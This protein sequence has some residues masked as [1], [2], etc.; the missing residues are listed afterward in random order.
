MKLR[1]KHGDLAIIIGDFPGCEENLGVIVKVVGPPELH[2]GTQ[3]ICWDIYPVKRRKL[4]L[5][6]GTTLFKTAIS[7]N[8]RAFHPDCWLLPIKG[9]DHSSALGSKIEKGLPAAVLD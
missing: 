8:N 4:W 7:K 9:S 5:L 3:M 6:D 2:K 1:C